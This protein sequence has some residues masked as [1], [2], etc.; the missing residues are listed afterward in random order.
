MG[1]NN[2]DRRDRTPQAP[3]PK[4]PEPA[5]AETIG[6]K[7]IKDEAATEAVGWLVIK[8]MMLVSSY[9][10]VEAAIRHLAPFLKGSV[11]GIPMIAKLVVSK[12]PVS[13]FGSTELAHAFRDIVDK[14]AHTLV[15]IIEEKGGEA[16][17]ATEVKTAAEEA[18]TSVMGTKYAV[19]SGMYHMVNAVA[20]A[21]EPGQDKWPRFTL[22]E[23]HAQRT[24]ACPVCVISLAPE[25]AKA[26]PAEKSEAKKAFKEPLEI[27]G[28]YHDEAVRKDF[29]T[30]F[31]GLSTDERKRVTDAFKH[32]S[33]D[34]EFRGFMSFE[35]ATRVDV[36]GLLESRDDGRHVRGIMEFLGQASKDGAGMAKAVFQAAARQVQAFDDALAPQV[37]ARAAARKAGPRQGFLAKLIRGTII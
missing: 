25:E 20:H 16:P 37:S 22:A 15:R 4:A 24:P 26:A 11:E 13:W 30:W 31:T 34:D 8:L 2:R 10:P 18:I 28:K 35:P 32:L 23:L 19:N 5:A 14:I 17:T 3:E 36:I 6:G 29:M 27:I 33:S 9:K 12:M 21:H 7:S 1:R